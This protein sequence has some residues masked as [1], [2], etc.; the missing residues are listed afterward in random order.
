MPTCTW[1]VR[2]THE[3]CNEDN[4]EKGIKYAAYF[5]LCSAKE[6]KAMMKRKGD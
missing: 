1:D 5:G 2:T 3:E 6:C 4:L